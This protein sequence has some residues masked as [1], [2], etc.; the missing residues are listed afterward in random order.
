MAV[1]CSRPLSDRFRCVLQ[2]F[3]TKLEGSP[4]PGASACLI[5]AIAAPVFNARH[6]WASD[7]GSEACDFAVFNSKVNNTL[8]YRRMMNTGLRFIVV[9][10]G[11]F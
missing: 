10:I 9:S 6:S 8:T 5:K 11:R 7:G 2:S 4:V 1:A 3:K